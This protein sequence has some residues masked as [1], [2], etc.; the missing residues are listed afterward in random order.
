MVRCDDHSAK[1]PLEI[2][3][4][5]RKGCLANY[6]PNIFAAVRFPPAFPMFLL[7]I[8][9]RMFASVRYDPRQMLG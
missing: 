4:P 1:F 3:P 6:C 7:R 8:R 2:K 9:L 5:W